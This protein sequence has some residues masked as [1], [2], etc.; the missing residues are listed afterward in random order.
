MRGDLEHTVGRRVDDPFAGLLV[1][2]T[3]IVEHLRAGCRTVAQHT[4]SRPTREL[5]DHL[6]GKTRRVGRERSC[7]DEPADL[8][9]P[10][11]AVL[12]GARRHADAERRLR[13]RGRRHPRERRTAPEAE[14]G[15]IGQSKAAN[16]ARDVAEGV[17][18][19]VTV[20]GAIG[21]RPDAETVQHDDRGATRHVMIRVICDHRDEELADRAT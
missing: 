1:L 2:G 5:G 20:G 12:P 19:G 14:R 16:G 21:C 11:R 15:K 10:S 17:A 13:R 9:M 18:S 6:G 7:N 8:P 4:A 3:E